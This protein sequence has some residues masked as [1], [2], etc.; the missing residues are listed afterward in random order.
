MS[1]GVT[2]GLRPALPLP[3]CVAGP[4]GPSVSF[5]MM[6]VQWSVVSHRMAM[7][8]NSLHVLWAR[9]WA[10]TA[11][12]FLRKDKVTGIMPGTDGR[13]LTNA[14]W[15]TM[16]TIWSQGGVYKINNALGYILMS[17]L[18]RVRTAQ[19]SLEKW[20]VTVQYRVTPILQTNFL[21]SEIITE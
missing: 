10:H 11:L 8:S 1:P 13:G 12:L 5:F 21:A 15:K 6:W 19:V 20:A 9:R 16:E 2:P 18:N 7:K 17:V 3:S 4:L 14:P